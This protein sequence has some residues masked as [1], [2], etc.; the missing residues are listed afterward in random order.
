MGDAPDVGGSASP[1]EARRRQSLRAERE[2]P[3]FGRRE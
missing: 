2:A 1:S 3:R